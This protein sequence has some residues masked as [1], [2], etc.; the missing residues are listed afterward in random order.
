MAQ[1]RT[2]IPSLET[3]SSPKDNIM[4]QEPG[5]SRV[6]SDHIVVRVDEVPSESSSATESSLSASDDDASTVSSDDDDVDTQHT[7]DARQTKTQNALIV[8]PDRTFQLVSDFPA[9]EILA[10]L[11]VMIRNYATGLNH[12]DWKSTE[13]NMCLPVLPWVLGREMA[14]IVEEVGS[15]VTSLK[16]GDRVWTSKFPGTFCTGVRLHGIR[17]ILQGYESRVFSR[18]SR[19]PATHRH[20]YP[21]QPRL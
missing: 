9:P 2:P 12:I 17:H 20:A 7:S 11:E 14:G 5:R 8:S 10:P 19:C 18:L 4:M 3:E 15:D 21:L 6:N 13:Y 16:K 1:T